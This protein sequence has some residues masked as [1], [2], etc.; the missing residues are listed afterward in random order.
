ML[1]FE[2]KDNNFISIPGSN[3]CQLKHCSERCV[4]ELAITITVVGID[5]Y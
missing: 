5:R 2:Q 4:N 3:S 1:A